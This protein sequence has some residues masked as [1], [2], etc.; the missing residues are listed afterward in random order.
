M[1]APTIEQ[2]LSYAKP[3]VF[4]FI[5]QHSA[6]APPEHKEE[7]EQNAYLRLIQAFPTII[8]DQGWKSFVYNHV[9]GAVLDYSKFGKGFQESRWSLASSPDESRTPKLTRRVEVYADGE[10]SDDFDVDRALAEN[11][12]F[13]TVTFDRLKIRWELLAK[14]SSN[15]EKIHAFARYLRGQTVEEMAHIFSGGNGKGV[16]RTR[17]SQMIQ[18]LLKW[19]DDPLMAENPHFLQLCYALGVCAQLG[20]PDV[21]QSV[22]APEFGKGGHTL[23]PVDLDFIPTAG[24]DPQMRFALEDEEDIAE[25]VEE[26]P[27]SEGIAETFGD[28]DLEPEPEF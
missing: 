28:D 2:V 3:L 18:E 19:F 8:A 1:D 22:A 11:G 20:M 17:V 21:D 4:K 9:R 23:S 25:A 24:P 10:A 26:L 12:V 16:G 13:R 15:D 7:I 14:M 5:A 27:Q 6:D